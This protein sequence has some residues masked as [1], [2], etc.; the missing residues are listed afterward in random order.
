MNQDKA[1]IKALKTMEGPTLSDDFSSGM[2]N[3]IYLVAA[4][5]KRRMYIG[6]LCLISTVSLGL[7]SMA[8]YLLRDYLQENFTFQMPS[9]TSLLESVS[10]YGF[11]FYIAFLTI[12]LIA[13]DHYFR[14]MW[15]KHKT[16]TFRQY[17]T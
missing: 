7:I 5:K 3:R 8:V 11:G 2:M 13:L 9:L 1:I 12:I 15:Q 14:S 4:K 10:K 6:T 17:N 16:D